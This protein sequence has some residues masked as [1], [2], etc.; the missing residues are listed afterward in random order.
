MPDGVSLEWVYGGAVV[1]AREEPLV[2]WHRDIDSDTMVVRMT[3][4]S[5]TEGQTAPLPSSFQVQSVYP[6]PFNGQLQIL[7]GLSREEVLA[8]DVF[9]IEGRR[10][11]SRD[12][13]SIGAGW[14]RATWNANAASGYYFIRIRTSHGE[15][16]VRRVVLLR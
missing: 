7:F 13:G 3:F 5:G 2:R 8:L 14:H 10:V 16:E 6:N 11:Y 9:T 4:A 1:D 12:L 15:Q